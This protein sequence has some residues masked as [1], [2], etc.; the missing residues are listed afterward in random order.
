MMKGSRSCPDRFSGEIPTEKLHAF[1]S[2]SSNSAD[3]ANPGRHVVV[4]WI[5]F[6]QRPESV[7]LGKAITQLDKDSQGLS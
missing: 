2:N 3:R 5:Q 6:N 1:S 4:T 7:I